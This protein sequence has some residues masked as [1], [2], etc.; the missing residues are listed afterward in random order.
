[1]EYLVVKLNICYSRK[2]G[3]IVGITISSKYS[4]RS[5]FFDL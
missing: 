4:L 2:V 1:M 5:T 3:G